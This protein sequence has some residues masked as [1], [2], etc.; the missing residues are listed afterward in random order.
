VVAVALQAY[1][2][3]CQDPAAPRR[4]FAAINKADT[5]KL[6]LLAAFVGA[7]SWAAARGRALPRWSIWEGAVTVV[8]L[9]E[10]GLAYLASSSVLNAV[11][12]V[13]LPLLLL[14]VAAAS[15]RMLWRTAQSA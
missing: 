13:S 4:L 5:V 14:L 9:V 15:V 2:P 7:A 6:I 12:D 3:G 1:L 8:F 10:G 11:L